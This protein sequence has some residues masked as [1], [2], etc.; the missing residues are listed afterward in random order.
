MRG[1]VDGDV[2]APHPFRFIPA[3]AGNR[4]QAESMRAVTSVHP[5]ACGE[6]STNP[7]RV[8]AN[9]GSSPRMRGTGG[10]KCARSVLGRFIPAHAGNRSWLSPSSRSIEV[11]PRA[12]GEQRIG[13]SKPTAA[14]GSSP[15][16]RGTGRPSNE[17]LVPPRFIPAHAGNSARCQPGWSLR[18][19]HPRACGEQTSWKL[20]IYRY[21][22]KTEESTNYPASLRGKNETSFSPSKSTG[23]RRLRPAVSKA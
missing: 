10:R 23:M 17:A 13:V 21:S 20:L 19:V 14:R 2:P 3:H 8:I 11:H 7:G 5:R 6:Q 16:M 1:T 18:P 12:C 22:S 9:S 4:S 15:R